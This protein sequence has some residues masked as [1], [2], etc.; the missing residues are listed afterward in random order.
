[1]RE[2]S[3][4]GGT[5]VSPFVGEATKKPSPFVLEVVEKLKAESP[6]V[7]EAVRKAPK[8]VVHKNAILLQSLMLP[9]S[10]L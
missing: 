4:S 9:E 6:F 8:V 1:M 2:G 10:L 5:I 7:T 3:A